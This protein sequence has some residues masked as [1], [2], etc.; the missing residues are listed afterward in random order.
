MKVAA[1]L[2]YT[3]AGTIAV[4]FGTYGVG[5]LARG[6]PVPALLAGL[7]LLTVLGAL[8]WWGFR[9]SLSAPG[10]QHNDPSGLFWTTEAREMVGRKFALVGGVLG[11]GLAVSVAVFAVTNATDPAAEA[12]EALLAHLSVVFMLAA[13]TGIFVLFPLN[14]TLRDAAGDSPARRKRINHV[15]LDGKHI[16]LDE[17]EKLLAVRVATMAP[18]FLPLQNF[19]FAYLYGSLAMQNIRFLLVDPG[20]VFPTVLLIFLAV[21]VVISIPRIALQVRRARRYANQ[22]AALL[23]G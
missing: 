2:I 13:V 4:L 18:V 19:G 12:L 10:S 8:A 17:D 11:S 7:G 23:A 15:A 16:A 22:N 20:D 6:S 3:I 5:Q 9:R 21:V 14:S 1:F